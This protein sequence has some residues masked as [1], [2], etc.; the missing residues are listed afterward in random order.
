MTADYKKSAGKRELLSLFE[1]QV[2]DI[3]QQLGEQ[4]RCLD[5]RLEAQ[6]SL[7]SELQEYFRRRAEVELEYS[8]ALDK[9]ARAIAARPR[10]AG[11]GERFSAQGCW[12]Q[13]VANARRQGRDHA[14][15]AEVYGA[16]LVAQ[17]AHLLEDVQRI[18]RK[19]RTIGLQQHDELLKVGQR[20]GQA[21]LSPHWSGALLVAFQRGVSAY[22]LKPTCAVTTRVCGYNFYHAMPAVRPTCRNIVSKN[23]VHFADTV[24]AYSSRGLHFLAGIIRPEF[25]WEEICEE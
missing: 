4:L 25:L 20:H 7:V 18:H 1:Q 17:L 8:R 16:V 2:K 24:R 21:P 22:G 11:S 6:L 10:G 12:E 19:C 9:M 14:A 5:A 15:L 3:R 13:L 23:I